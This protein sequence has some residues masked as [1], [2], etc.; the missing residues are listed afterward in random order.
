MQFKSSRYA[1]VRPHTISF[2][3]YSLFACIA[4]GMQNGHAQGNG[5][6]TQHKQT[7]LQY[8]GPKASPLVAVALLNKENNTAQQAADWLAGVR[9]QTLVTYSFLPKSDKYI[10]ETEASLDSIFKKAADTNA[11]LF[12]DEA[13]ALFGK[14]SQT[15]QEKALAQKFLLL[16]KKP[17]TVI[18]VHCTGETS[19]FALAKGG[20]GIVSLD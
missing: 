5:L 11:L 12:F 13:D 17:A 8:C 9:K 14:A 3:L 15:P 10:G 2:F 18:L 20:F 1:T 7:L 6:T 19:Y 4:F 16:A